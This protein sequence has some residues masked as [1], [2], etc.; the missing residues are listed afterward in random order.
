MKESGIVLFT[1]LIFIH[2]CKIIISKYQGNHRKKVSHLVLQEIYYKKA[3]ATNNGLFYSQLKML[4][5]HLCKNLFYKLSI[6]TVLLCYLLPY[7]LDTDTYCI[8]IDLSIDP[9]KLSLI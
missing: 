4:V 5:M 9:L 6:T 7:L 3:N 8:V 1:F 2:C